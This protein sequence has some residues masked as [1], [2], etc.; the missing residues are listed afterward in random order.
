[1]STVTV[2]TGLGHAGAVSLAVCVRGLQRVRARPVLLIPTVVMPVFFVISFTGAFS[3]LTR[4]EG[5]G[6]SNIFN[7]MAP[8]AALQGAVFA[9][10]GGATSAADD[11]ESGFFDRLL[12]TPGSRLPILIGTIG[13]SAVRSFIPTT[14]VLAV[15]ALGGLQL[16]G[17][18]LGLVSLFA[19]TAGMAVVFCLFG[20]TIV[21]RLRTLRSMMIV[22]VVGFSSMF[23]SIGQVPIEFLDGW[24]HHA[25][26]LNPLTNVLRLSRQGFVGELSWDLTWP[27]L[28]A[29]AAMTLV[30]GLSALRA[31]MK[32]AP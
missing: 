19:A 3:S 22:Q 9:G 4:I 20:L 21:Y 17:G 27:G 13:Y 26:R 15:A 8:Y 30:G 25:A 23:L 5:Y 14:G 1:V 32:M 11:L 31:L 24:L 29:I 18:V 7:W 28:V 12:L 16:P 6:T 10:V 2:S